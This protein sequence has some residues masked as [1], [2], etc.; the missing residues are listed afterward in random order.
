MKDDRLRTPVESDYVEALGRTAYTFAS[1]EWQVV[2]CL[3]KIRPNDIRK[4]VGEEMT[5]GKIGKRFQDAV[6]NMPKSPE[7]ELLQNLASEFLQLVQVRN[8]IMHGKPCTSPKGDQR[9]SGS[10]VI[11]IVDLENAAD[12]FV[13]CSCKLNDLSYGFLSSYSVK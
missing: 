4:V 10:S 1:L 7:R 6:R 8:N 3:E 12:D 5:A 2:W 13:E 9:L 11:E